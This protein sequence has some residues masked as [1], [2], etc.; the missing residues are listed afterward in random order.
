MDRQRGIR[1]PAG[2]DAALSIRTVYTEPS[3]ALRILRRSRNSS[4]PKP[5][6]PPAGGSGR[7]DRQAFRERQLRLRSEGQFVAAGA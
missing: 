4:W 2:M 3:R 1:K 6:R 5:R 7:L